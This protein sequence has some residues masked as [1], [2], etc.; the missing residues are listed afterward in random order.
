MPDNMTIAH[1]AQELSRIADRLDM[2]WVNLD[3]KVLDKVLD[4]ESEDVSRNWSAISTEFEDA[5]AMLDNVS[6]KLRSLSAHLSK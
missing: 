4:D 1:I 5:H 2:E 3:K 6:W